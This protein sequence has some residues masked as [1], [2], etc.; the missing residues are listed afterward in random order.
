[1]HDSRPVGTPMDPSYNELEAVKTSM[2]DRKDI[3]QYQSMVGSAMY[4]AMSTRIDVVYTLQVLSGH[5]REPRE[6]H[7][8]AAKHLFRYLKGTLDMCLKYP[9]VTQEDPVLTA[10]SDS[11]YAGDRLESKSTSG[12]VTYLGGCAVTWCSRR[13]KS[14][15]QSTLE[16]EYIALN[17][18]TKEV[19]WLRQI[20]E[21]LKEK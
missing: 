20:L 15:S 18:A 6:Y 17:E 21:E 4:A 16:A 8:T 3:K 2:L 5:L 10:Y 11:D 13:Q 12:Y 19:A 9:K 7:M 14:T 1:M